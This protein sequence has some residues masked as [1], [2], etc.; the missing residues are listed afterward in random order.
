MVGV[1]ILPGELVDLYDRQGG[2]LDGL[3][4]G[5]FPLARRLGQVAQELT[6]W[7]RAEAAR[8]AADA[9]LGAEQRVLAHLAA[10]EPWN[11]LMRRT[12][13][14]NLPTLINDD[15]KALAQSP[16]KSACA[17]STTSLLRR[18]QPSS[19]RSSG[20]ERLRKSSRHGWPGTPSSRAGR[21]ISALPITGKSCAG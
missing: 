5:G 8:L 12:P 17:C 3:T 21:S 19:G 11:A 14:L 7:T 9:S 1:E 15:L 16:A 4:Y 10:F 2:W 13:D 18:C 20:L 6:G